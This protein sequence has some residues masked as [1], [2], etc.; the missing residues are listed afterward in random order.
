MTAHV[1][2]SAPNPTEGL[3]AVIDR[4]YSWETEGCG[5]AIMLTPRIS[6]KIL[7]PEQ[8]RFIRKLTI[9]VRVNRT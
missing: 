4:A 9:G 2:S 3:S 1:L 7:I 5:S 8:L 6:S